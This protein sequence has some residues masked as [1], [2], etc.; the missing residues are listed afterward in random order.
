M[1][2]PISLA[3][4]ICDAVWRDPG[5]GKW[6]ILGTFSQIYAKTFPAVHSQIGIYIE[7][8]DGRGTMPFSLRIVDADEIREPVATLEG[9]FESPDPRAVVQLGANLADLEFPQAGEYRVMLEV[10]GEFLVE[11]RVV[12]TGQN[13]PFEE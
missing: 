4:V 11:R 10:N 8:T 13:D 1:Q 2:P 9:N 6:T 7:L 12:V 3:M 5:T